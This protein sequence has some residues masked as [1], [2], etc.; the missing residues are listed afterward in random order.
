[1]KFNP[2]FTIS[3]HHLHVQT[4]ALHDTQQPSQ[5]QQTHTHTHAHSHT[6]FIL[7]PSTLCYVSPEV[8]NTLQS[9][10]DQ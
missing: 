6:D 10:L 5:T 4:F 3:K 9:S 7:L 1:M 2:L 8:S